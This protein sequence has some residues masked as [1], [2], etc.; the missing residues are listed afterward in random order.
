MAD[1]KAL[2]EDATRL[3][4]Q[5][6]DSPD[7]VDPAT[8]AGLGIDLLYALDDDAD[9]V[10]LHLVTSLVGFALHVAPEHSSVPEWWSEL[11]HAHGWIAE[12]TDSAT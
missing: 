1:L 6:R 2:H 7:H 10:A 4:A 8:A 11:G 9:T 3:A 5:L 12:Q